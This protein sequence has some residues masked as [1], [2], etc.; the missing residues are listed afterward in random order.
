MSF[1]IPVFVLLVMPALPTTQRD[2]RQFGR[3]SGYVNVPG[4]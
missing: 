2:R 3:S 4:S 1:L